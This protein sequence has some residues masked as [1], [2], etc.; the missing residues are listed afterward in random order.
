MQ[1]LLSRL[2]H[3]AH[4]FSLTGQ[5]RH[6]ASGDYHNDSLQQSA[7]VRYRDRRMHPMLM[8]TRVRTGKQCDNYSTPP[9]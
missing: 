6:W 9:S 3:P 4:L 2:V 5:S 1:V 7:R 8:G